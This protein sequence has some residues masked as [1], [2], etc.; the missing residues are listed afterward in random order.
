[1][2]E[3]LFVAIA[4]FLVALA[5]DVFDVGMSKNVDAGPITVEYPTENWGLTSCCS[6]STQLLFDGGVRDGGCQP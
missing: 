3:T 6:G 5:L 1:M 2:K 4:L